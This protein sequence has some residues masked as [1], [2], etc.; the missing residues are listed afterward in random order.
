MNCVYTILI[1]SY[2]CYIGVV[3]NIWIC[4]LL[5][6]PWLYTVH[7]YALGKNLHNCSLPKP[8]GYCFW[9]LNATFKNI[10][11]ISSV[12]LVKKSSPK[13]KYELCVYY[14]NYFLFLLHW[15]CIEYLNLWF[16]GFALA[17]RYFTFI[18]L[19]LHIVSLYILAFLLVVNGRESVSKERTSI[20][21]KFCNMQYTAD[22]T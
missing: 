10:S 6:L 3:L 15:C 21:P 4:D 9:V 8:R 17:I 7:I 12:V 18:L 5:V 14:F 11:I 13:H 20:K 1:I 2:F 22:K 19:P 16:A